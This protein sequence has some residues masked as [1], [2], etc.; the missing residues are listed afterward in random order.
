LTP[1]ALITADSR[2][3]ADKDR[4]TLLNRLRHLLGLRQH[5]RIAGVRYRELTSESLRHALS[6][7]GTGHK[8]YDVAFRDVGSMRI[9]CTRERIYADLAGPRLLNIFRLCESR[10][11]PG[12]RVL[13]TPGGTGYA[14]AWVAQLVAPSGSVV[15]LEPDEESVAYAKLRYRLPNASFEAGGVESLNGETDGAFDAAISVEGLAPLDD[16]PRV[17]AELWR[18]IR[19]GGWLMS[20][21]KRPAQETAAVLRSALAPESEVSVLH[22]VP[23][24]WGAVVAERPAEG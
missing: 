3:R 15:S 24:G 9:C 18:T 13:I 23:G 2:S 10:I 1:A 17:L 14:G 16:E 4:R 6:R 8:D 12:M 11:R 21:A 7:S 22:D 20:T 5:I 19:P